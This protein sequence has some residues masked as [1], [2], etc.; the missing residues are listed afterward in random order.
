MKIIRILILLLSS[1]LIHNSC[2]K[3][4][5]TPQPKVIGTLIVDLD[6]NKN[7]VRKKEALIG[8]L[9][10]DAMKK[11]LDDRNK[12]VDCFIF[13]GGDMRF[14][15]TKRPNGIYPA[16]DFTVEMVDEMLPFGNTNVIVKI[17]GKQ[18]KEVLER[19]VAQYPLAQGPF[20]QVS[21]E[22]QVIIDT[23]KA[24]QTLD[25]NS[26]TI[27][28]HGA[29]ITSIKIN[30]IPIDSLTEYFVGTSNYIAEGNDGYVTFKNIPE[31]LKENIGEDQANALKEFV[32]TNSRIE[33]KLEGRLI[34][35]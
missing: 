14:S 13:N 9:I 23:T 26:T 2:A 10:L 29:R 21:R 3:K 15:A 27:V 4:N 30:N 12:N 31:E 24:P 20:L 6:A 25:V 22:M 17:T 33:P 16:G 5:R 32:I 1:M 18:L 19:S 34:F 28:S 8:N 35:Q 11:D 7:V